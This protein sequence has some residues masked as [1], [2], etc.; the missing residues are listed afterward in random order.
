MFL[1]ISLNSLENTCRKVCFCNKVAGCSNCFWSSLHLLLKIFCLFHF[2]R[3]MKKKK[4]ITW[5]SS[6]IYFFA[7]VLICLTSNHIF[8][9]N[10]LLFFIAITQRAL[11][12]YFAWKQLKADYSKNI[13]NEENCRHSFACLLVGFISVGKKTK[14]P[15]AILLVQELRI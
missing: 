1:E 8:P 9:N 15:P 14:K 10:K 5:W 6:N 11:K 12:V 13:W 7:R 2:N 3:K 4:E